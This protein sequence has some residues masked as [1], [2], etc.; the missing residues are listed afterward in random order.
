M[1]S[2]VI[3]IT[4]AT[5]GIGMATCE[6]LLAVGT[7]IIG[8][9]RNEDAVKHI[10]SEYPNDFYFKK[11]DLKDLEGIENLFVE[12]FNQFGKFDGLIHCAG[13][14]ETLPL[15]SYNSIKVKNIFEINVFT[16][17]EFIRVFSKKK[18]SNDFASIILISSVMG[19]LGQPGKVGYCATKSAI[20]G[21][22]R[23]S[24]L[25]LSKRK[26]RV[27][28]VSPGVVYT[29]MTDKLF[30]NL[31]QEAIKNITNMHPLGI[32]NVND[33]VPLITFLASNDSKWITGQNLIVDG[34]YS[35]Q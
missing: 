14:E 31:T 11:Y 10:L 23:S 30:K 33:V 26:I 35:C 8:I 1:E 18:Y 29:P 22:V 4:G 34:G 17:I 3:I 28:A 24:A 13:F 32:G 20:L 25:E 2:K 9:G 15:I 7:K 5:S 16:S 19:E 12:F 6:K 21:I 27:N